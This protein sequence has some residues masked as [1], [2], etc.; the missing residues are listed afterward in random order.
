MDNKDMKQIMEKAEVLIEALR[1]LYMAEVRRSAA[2]SVRLVKK[3]NL[4]TDCV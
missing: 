1:S 4:S 2:G 3:Q